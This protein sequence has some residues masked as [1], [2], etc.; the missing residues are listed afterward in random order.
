MEEKKYVSDRID[1]TNWR[2]ERSL[3]HGTTKESIKKI[4]ISKFDP[5][6]AGKNG[7]CK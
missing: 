3:W 4:I 7:K 2:V 1:T 5:G 6:L